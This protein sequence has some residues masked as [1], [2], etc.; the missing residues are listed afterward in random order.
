[1]WDMA[2]DLARHVIDVDMYHTAHD[3][4]AYSGGLFWHTTHYADAGTSTHRSYSR[5]TSRASGGPSSEHNYTTGL[6]LHYFMTGSVASKNA[7]LELAAWVPRMDDGHL[8]P[9][10]W[11]TSSATGVASATADP[12]YHGPGRGAGNSINALLDAHRLTLESR[13][14]DKAEELIHRCI[15][16]EDDVDARE[17]LDAERRWSY[18]VF[19]QIL[20]KYLDYKAILGAF[21]DS[22]LYAQASLLRYARW[23]AGH[24]QPYL[25]TPEKLEYP[26]VTWAAQDMRKAEVFR[27]AARHSSGAE[28]ERF[29][30]RSH[31]FFDYALSALEASP[32]RA[33]TRPIVILLTNGYAQGRLHGLYEVRQ[34][35]EHPVKFQKSAPFVP[36]KAT[37]RRRVAIAGAVAI[38]VVAAGLLSLFW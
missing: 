36:Q 38:V 5:K 19:L 11:L 35:P 1:L 27:F 7:V 37:V 4:A 24:E 16:P 30:D 33:L 8:T 31:F 15:H 14:L 23:M 28:R 25:A 2:D 20:G 22:Y 9:F 21:D 34:P 32:T 29:L 26:T 12:S 18:T 6:M 3:K 17:L 13:W 10:R